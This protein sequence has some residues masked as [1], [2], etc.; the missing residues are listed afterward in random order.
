[1]LEI[2]AA[3][4]AIEGTPILRDVS[5]C[6][7]A[8]N[9]VG[10]VG[11]NGAGKT[12]CLRTIM[13]LLKPQ[14]GRIRFDGRDVTALGSDKR[15]ALGIGY[16]PEDRKLVP[17]LTV[18]ENIM[19]PAWA[20]K[21]DGATA[22][23][24]WI[25]ALIPELEP[26]LDRRAPQLSGGQQKLV[27]LGRALMIGRHALL[28]DEPSEG[29]APALAQRIGEILANLKREG[30]CILIAESNDHHVADLLDGVFAIERGH[31]TTFSVEK[32]H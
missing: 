23:A 26:L 4:V 9:M 14:G 32:E 17:E 2:E 12:T 10:L 6:V 27:A 16:M 19:V 7:S 1:M 11:R 30:P 18:R 8:G 31:V 29:V 5:F 24:D 20:M 13:G 3:S 25:V 22:R 28:L 21:L 15:A